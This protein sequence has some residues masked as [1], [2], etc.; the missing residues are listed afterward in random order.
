[1]IYRI[2]WPEKR[3]LPEEQIRTAY[4]EAVFW[5]QPVHDDQVEE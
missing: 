3:T 1:M 5:Y 4:Q 2:V